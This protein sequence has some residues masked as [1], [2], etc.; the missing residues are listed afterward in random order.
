MANIGIDSPR[1]IWKGFFMECI[2]TIQPTNI[3]NGM[4]KVIRIDNHTTREGPI[5]QGIVK[6]QLEIVE[7]EKASLFPHKCSIHFAL[8]V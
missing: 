6:T 4:N 5:E 2:R 8:I 3:I 7:V 1:T